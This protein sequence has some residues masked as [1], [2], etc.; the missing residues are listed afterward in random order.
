MQREIDLTGSYVNPYAGDIEEIVDPITGEKKKFEQKNQN[1]PNIPGLGGEAPTD[2]PS[3]GGDDDD[4]G[5]GGGIDDVDEQGKS[6]L[7]VLKDL[8]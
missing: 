5:E 1:R 8:L 7:D 4:S 3:G 6:N 2:E